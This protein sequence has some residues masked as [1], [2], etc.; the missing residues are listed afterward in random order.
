MHAKEEGESVW[1]KTL[2]AA[3]TS[4]AKQV[5]VRTVNNENMGVGGMSV[6]WQS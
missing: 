5:G 6:F 3:D 4:S 1:L 2:E